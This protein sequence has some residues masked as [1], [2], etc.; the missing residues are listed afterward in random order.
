MAKLI[1]FICAV[2]FIL[3]M[4]KILPPMTSAINLVSSREDKVIYQFYPTASALKVA[5]ALG[6]VTKIVDLGDVEF[7]NT[8]FHDFKNAEIEKKTNYKRLVTLFYNTK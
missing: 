5:F 6:E 1:F 7:M 2:M 4:A 3:A 8:S